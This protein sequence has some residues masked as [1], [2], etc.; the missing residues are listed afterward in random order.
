MP[1]V[2]SKKDASAKD[3]KNDATANA[4]AKNAKRANVAPMVITIA[5]NPIT[6]KDDVTITGTLISALRMPAKRATAKVALK[7]ATAM[8]DAIKSMTDG[9]VKDANLRMN[10]DL[11]ADANATIEATA[12]ADADA[13][14]AYHQIRAV[15]DALNTIITD[16]EKDAEMA[17]VLANDAK[18]AKNAKKDAKVND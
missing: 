16:A 11:I 7:D 15:I 1:N 5:K 8:M 14:S 18:N 12:N 9:A 2:N 3:A 4:D 13:L 17:K 6:A 10:A